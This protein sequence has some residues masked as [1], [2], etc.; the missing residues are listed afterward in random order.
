MSHTINTWLLAWNEIDIAKLIIKHYQKFSDKVTIMDN[1]STDGTPDLA[2]DMGCDVI[3]FGDKYFD[4]KNNMDCKNSCWQSDKADYNIV[5]DFDEV[6]FYH[7]GSMGD[8]FDQECITSLLHG[9]PYDIY[10]TIGWQIMSDEIPKDDLLE[11]TTGFRFDNY[12]KSILF[13]GAIIKMD[14]NPGAHRCNPVNCRGDGIDY[15][16]E[17]SMYVL[18]YKHIGGVQRT[19]DRYREYQPRM[20]KLNRRK[21]WGSHYDR[22]EQSIREEWNERM[23]KSRPL[24]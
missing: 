2:R 11:I 12:S 16:N 21:G 23:A 18:H 8:H 22:T 15:S 24:I 5:A 14:F 7:Q 10:K 4:D 1:Y 19:I 6:L 9:S 20:S 17:G 3:Q 13:S